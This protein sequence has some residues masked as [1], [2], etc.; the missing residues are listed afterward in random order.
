MATSRTKHVLVLGASL[1][2]AMLI[3]IYALLELFVFEIRPVMVRVLHYDTELPIEGAVVAVRWYSSHP[4]CIHG[5]CILGEAAVA[6]VRTGPYGVVKVYPQK[7]R[8]SAHWTATHNEAIFVHK[9]GLVVAATTGM[10][11]H[12]SQSTQKTF[13]L[14]PPDDFA[15][16]PRLIPATAKPGRDERMPLN[17]QQTPFPL[18]ESEMEQTIRLFRSRTK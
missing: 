6:E 4:L 11:I 16:G 12:S 14:L 10:D 18:L 9:A 7:T 13:F 2:I 3:V 8:W 5:D 17:S 15:D 1:A